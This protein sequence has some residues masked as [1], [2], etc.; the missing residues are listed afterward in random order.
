MFCVALYIF[1]KEVRGFA[2][3][4]ILEYWS[5]G[6][7]GLG[8]RLG[9]V[10]GLRVFWEY[11]NEKARKRIDLSC[12]TVSPKTFLHYSTIPLFHG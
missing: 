10:I 2:P 11:H 8:L 12:E 6:I 3:N 9:E 4:G 1:T 7:L 5:S